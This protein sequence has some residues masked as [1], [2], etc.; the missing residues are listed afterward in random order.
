MPSVPTA[1]YQGCAQGIR[2]EAPDYSTLQ[3]LQW[4]A[5]VVSNKIISQQAAQTP[6]YT[7]HHIYYHFVPVEPGAPANSPSSHTRRSFFSTP[8]WSNPSSAESSPKVRPTRLSAQR[9]S[10]ISVGSRR[11]AIS[12]NPPPPAYNDEHTLAEPNQTQPAEPSHIQTQLAQTRT[13]SPDLQAQYAC[14]QL[15]NLDTQAPVELSEA[16]RAITPKEFIQ[17]LQQLLVQGKGD[18][19]FRIQ[20][21]EIPVSVWRSEPNGPFL[22]QHYLP[23]GQKDA[24][25]VAH[26][27]NGNGIMWCP[28]PNPERF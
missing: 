8:N 19:Q 14:L 23:S 20:G 25:S 16:E 13:E 21:E 5:D 11:G 6:R 28:P 10:R 4:M 26:I 7:E 24:I 1:Y 12:Y 2:P 22:V 18:G 17:Q 9:V 27:V 3:H 15:Q